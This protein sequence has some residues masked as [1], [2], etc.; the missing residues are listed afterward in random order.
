[1]S[2]HKIIAV[3]GATGA[4]GGGLARAI[5]ADRSHGFVARAITRNPGSDK[6]S[7]LRALG[8][9][10]VAGDADNPASL[11]RAFAGAYGA[12]CVTNFWEHSSAEREGKQAGAMAHASRKAGLTHVVW[13][14]LEDTREHI[15]LTDTRMPTLHGKYNV[16]HFDSKGE[17]NRVFEQVAAPTSFLEAAFYWE[18]FI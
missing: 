4:Q 14:T 18:N 5:A 12:F 6:A 17:M 7:A 1:M 10:V 8:I 13:S 3:I 9:E 11:E 16:P 15:P 2:D